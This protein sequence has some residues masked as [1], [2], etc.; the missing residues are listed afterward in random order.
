MQM[1][2]TSL[3]CTTS[4]NS[5]C[6]QRGAS[7]TAYRTLSALYSAHDVPTTMDCCMRANCPDFSFSFIANSFC[8]SP[9]HKTNT[10]AQTALAVHSRPCTQQNRH[11]QFVDCLICTPKMQAAHA[12]DAKLFA[13]QMQA[14]LSPRHCHRLTTMKI[15]L[16]GADRCS[17]NVQ[18]H[19][20]PIVV[21]II[22]VL[23]IHLLHSICSSQNWLPSTSSSLSPLAIVCG[24]GEG[25]PMG[26]CANLASK[27]NVAGASTTL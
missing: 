10:N 7:H 4:F 15:T 17:P 23:V 16:D 9:Q 8:F 21:F 12:T 22:V 2:F 19:V 26:S 1:R 13:P 18:L 27:P 25:G 5:P 3:Q 14:A 11:T 20:T 6:T 24:G